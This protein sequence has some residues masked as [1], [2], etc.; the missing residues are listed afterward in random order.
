VFLSKVLTLRQRHPSQIVYLDAL[1]VERAVAG[2][3]ALG[4]RGGE[5]C[6]D[7]LTSAGKP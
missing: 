6:L 5:P 2:D 4:G 3:D 7:Q 1:Q